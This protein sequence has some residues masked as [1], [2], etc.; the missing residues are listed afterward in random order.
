MKLIII[1]GYSGAGKSVALKAFED[2]GIACMDNI[3]MS[4]ISAMLGTLESRLEVLAICSDVRS[5]DFDAALF[6][7]ELAILK[8]RYG[9]RLLFLTCQQDTLVARFNAT[10]HRHP[11][12][13]GD[14]V[15][16]SLEAERLMLAPLRMA[17]DDVIDTSHY[18]PHML[19]SHLMQLAGIGIAAGQLAVQLVSF[20][21]QLGLPENADLVFDVRFL[22]NPHYEAALRLQTGRDAEVAAFIAQDTHLS[23]YLEKV[24]GLLEMLVPLY[25]QEGKSYLT[26]AI[27]CTG[28]RHRSV[29]VAETLGKRLTSLACAV[30]VHHRE[31]DRLIP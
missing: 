2:A 27:G 18:T 23:P 12:Y 13:R 21:Y 1:T 26:I 28:G 14:S 31:S 4:V 22:R 16:D 15:M 17:A 20:S 8:S 9:C 6:L 24:S 29:Y 30:T 11:L 3:P 19:K 5:P 7:E 25:Q 10:K